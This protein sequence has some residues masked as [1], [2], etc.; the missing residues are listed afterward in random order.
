MG[1]RHE[2]NQVHVIG[3]LGTAGILGL[4][5]GSLAV[6][7]IASAA[8]IGDALFTGKIRPQQGRRQQRRVN[9]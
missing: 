6:F 3:S 7:V 4:A 5:T 2:L 9:R 1:A 8:L